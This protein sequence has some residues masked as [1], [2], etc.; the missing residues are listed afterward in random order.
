[1]FKSILRGSGVLL[2]GIFGLLLGSCGGMDKSQ[3][4]E[5]ESVVA[6]AMEN[7]PYDYEML[8]E[9]STSGYVVFRLVNPRQDIGVNVA[10]GLPTSNNR[11]S[12]PPLREPGRKTARGF[13]GAASQPLICIAT[14]GWRDG[15]SREEQLVRFKMS[16]E[17]LAVALCNE[18]YDKEPFEDFV[19]FD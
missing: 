8:P 16:G 10:F 9:L 14:D 2:I 12:K 4:S 18:V 11:C 15:G 3:S 1:M 19:C 13:V 5:L 7:L 6:D 17:T